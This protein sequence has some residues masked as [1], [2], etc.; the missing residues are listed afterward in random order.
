[1]TWQS[2]GGW[3][4]T[5]ERRLFLS[6]PLFIISES[7]LAIYIIVAITVYLRRPGR[8]LAR[9]PTSMAAIIS[10]FAASAAVQDM[11]QT[12]HLNKKDRADHLR[13]LGSLYGYGSYV[14]GGDGRVHIGIEK[15]PFVRIRSKSTWFEEKV[16]SFRKGSAVEV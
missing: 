4:V 9:M 14:G 5:T 12:S 11:R 8:Y 16:K 6:T 13:S 15:T 7:I 3:K 10:L 2:I 1:M